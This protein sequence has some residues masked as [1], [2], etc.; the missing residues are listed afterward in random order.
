M[1][2][3]VEDEEALA[4]SLSFNLQQ[5]GFEVVV[6]GDGETALA[7][8][9]VMRPDLILLD[10]MVPKLDGRELCKELRARRYQQPILFLTAR[11]SEMDKVVGLEVGADDYIT[12]PFSTNELV[13]RIRAH[14]R[15]FKRL[16]SES[17]DEHLLRSG[18]L[19]L[20]QLRREVKIQGK[21]VPLTPLEFDL[22]CYLLNNCD[23]TLNRRELLDKVWGY[24]CGGD[25]SV[26]NVAVQRLRDKVK[27]GVVITTV[28]GSGYRLDS[29]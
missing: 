27:E 19:S 2:L 22:L 29:Q 23:R 16:S 6:I 7:Q 25:A 11:D 10:V 18:T 20:D 26:V 14:L 5:E 21:V 4:E 3:L 9:E 15:R 17:H 13:A 12:K 28:R 8:V 24:A 1:V